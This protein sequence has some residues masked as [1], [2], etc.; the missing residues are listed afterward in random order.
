MDESD[1]TSAVSIIVRDQEGA[2]VISTRNELSW[3]TMRTDGACI[4]HLGQPTDPGT[5]MVSL[6]LDGM[7]VCD[8]PITIT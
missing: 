1:S 5:Y 2:F 6:Y 3:N 7:H 8:L 4:L